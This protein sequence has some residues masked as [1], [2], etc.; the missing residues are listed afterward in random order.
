MRLESKKY[1]YDIAQAAASAMEFIGRKTFPD[2][3]SD[4]MLLSAVERQL[5]IVGE[6]R[7]SSYPR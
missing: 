5:E 6:A 1:L 2:Y 7:L 3:T 4:A